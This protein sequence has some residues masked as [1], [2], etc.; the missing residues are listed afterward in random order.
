MKMFFKGNKLI[1]IVFV[2]SLVV[3]LL[4][5]MTMDNQELFS[6]VEKWFNIVFQL[7]IGFV[8]NFMFYVT[9]VYVPEI[10]QMKKA[11]ACVY[12]RIDRIE[13]Y[14]K[15]M[16]EHLAQRY[17][18]DFD[19][20]KQI[21]TEQFIT[22]MHNLDFDHEVNV[23]NIKRA[24]MHNCHFTVK[25]WMNSRMEFIEHDI[26]KLYIY[27]ATYISPELMEV[28]EDILKSSM[29]QDMGRTF[30]HL[31][32]KV[33]F[34]ECNDDI[35]FEPYYKLMKRLNEVKKQYM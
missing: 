29:H 33:T 21:T 25:E 18:E 2:I 6:H 4:Y 14:M 12:K 8:I 20:S 15:E 19:Y 26:D 5:V 30:S 17:V 3:I 13:A 9:Q 7:A 32:Q 1:S 16:L 28:L 31:P 10:K 11:N 22:I 34:N 24:N 23:I 35:F 27:Y